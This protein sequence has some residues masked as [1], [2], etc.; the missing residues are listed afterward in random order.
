MQ[1]GLRLGQ[2]NIYEYYRSALGEIRSIGLSAYIS[3]VSKPYLA[4]AANHLDPKQESYI[5]A[6]LEAGAS[7]WR[8]TQ[9]PCAHRFPIGA[10]PAGSMKEIV[11]TIHVH[12]E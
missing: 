10:Q 4:M 9:L 3:Q 2:A 6:G 1:A 7:A 5:E 8:Q 12:F 11:S